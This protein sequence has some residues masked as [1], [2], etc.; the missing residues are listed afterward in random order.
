MYRAEQLVHVIIMEAKDNTFQAAMMPEAFVTAGYDLS[1]LENLQEETA[2]KKVIQTKITDM[3][4]RLEQKEPEQIV[5]PVELI[6]K[7]EQ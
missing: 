7:Q 1:E 3:Y 5:K 4:K 6:T 2:D